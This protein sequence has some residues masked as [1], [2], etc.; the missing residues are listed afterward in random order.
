VG[1]LTLQVKKRLTVRASDDVLF[2]TDGQANLRATNGLDL[3]GGA[4]THVKGGIVR[5]G[6]GTT[7]VARMQDLVTVPVTAQPVILLFQS[8]PIP[9]VPALAV[10]TTGVPGLPMPLVGSI[11]TGNTKVLA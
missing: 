1:T 7:P 8:P 3:D 2:S 10:L 11:T 9:N 6:E 4:Y 5:L